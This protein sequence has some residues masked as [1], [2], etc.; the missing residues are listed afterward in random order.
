MADAMPLSRDR[1][2]VLYSTR[3]WLGSDQGFRGN[4]NDRSIIYQ[5]REG[6]PTGPILR[7]K[8][9][10]RY[11]E[12]WDPLGDG[13]RHLRQHFQ[14]GCFGVP[15]GALVHGKRVAHE[16][17][18]VAS[19]Y[20]CA[21]TK[22]VGPADIPPVAVDEELFDR[23]FDVQWV[24]FRLADSGDDIEIVQPPLA[25]RQLGFERGEQFCD[26]MP[27]CTMNM[28][29]VKPA[30]Y[31]SDMSQW[32]LVPHFSRG[33]AAIRLA[34][35]AERGVY[36]WVETG[37]LFCVGR[38]SGVTADPNASY[39]LTETSL[40]RHR[41]SWLIAARSAEPG[42]RNTPGTAWIRTDD[43]FRPL[44]KPLFPGAPRSN[45]PTGVFRCPDGVIRIFTGDASI[46]PYRNA[47]DPLYCWDV[48]VDNA[49]AIT[50]R[51]VVFDVTKAD[52][53][54]RPDTS[55]RIDMPNLLTHAGG[56]EQYISFRVR[57]R[58]SQAPVTRINDEEKR[59]SA[60]HHARI[61]YDED[62]PPA[63]QF[64][65]ALAHRSADGS[66]ETKDHR[67]FARDRRWQPRVERVPDVTKRPD[68]QAA[69]AQGGGPLQGST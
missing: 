18:F 21:R 32:V 47:R 63:W 57:L 46:S 65:D 59:R 31:N 44:P 26:I 34:F 43:L 5:V 7:E 17:H 6:G 27:R 64:D 55:P 30:P 2:F 67:S 61:L 45:A 25:L 33:I 22:G 42:S 3:G 37:K 56:R 41:D 48:D 68:P 28:W 53:F 12:D 13:S 11:I 52:L 8:A 60:L 62:H 10:A 58:R 1:W 16:N 51:R 50:N 29:Y 69:G 14:T 24:Q 66:G 23:V 35:S 20:C 54:V 49:F 39:R 40:L 15:K 36:E 38:Q 9:L 4:D 19:W